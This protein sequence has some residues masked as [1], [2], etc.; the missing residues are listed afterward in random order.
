MN[1]LLCSFLCLILLPTHFLFGLYSTG[2]SCF[3]P[4]PVHCHPFLFLHVRILFQHLPL[5]ALFIP[6]F[7]SFCAGETRVLLNCF[8]TLQFSFSPLNPT[9]PCT[10]FHP[11]P[12]RRMAFFSVFFLSDSEF[13]TTVYLS[14]PCLGP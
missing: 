12:P 5:A 1:R 4:V 9:P 2:I 7:S 13:D 14:S 11:P 6:L 3:F 8:L 10:P